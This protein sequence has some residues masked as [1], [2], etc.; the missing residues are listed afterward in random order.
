M[1]YITNETVHICLWVGG[2]LVTKAA[3]VVVVVVH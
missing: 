1:Q 3:V 2:I